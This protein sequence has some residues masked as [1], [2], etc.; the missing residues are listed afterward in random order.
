[1]PAKPLKQ[2]PEGRGK[3]DPLNLGHLLPER[4]ASQFCFDLLPLS[5]IGRNTQPICQFKE[6]AFLPL[7]PLPRSSGPLAY[8]IVQFLWF[9]L[10]GMECAISN[11]LI[12]EDKAGFESRPLRSNILLSL[13]YCKLS[14]VL[15]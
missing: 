10:E 11:L 12:L 14:N 7:V 5:G 8:T 4:Q 13:Y 15:D 2:V 3:I 9:L 1:M 6:V